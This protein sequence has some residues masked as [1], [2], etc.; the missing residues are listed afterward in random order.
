MSCYVY[1]G[2]KP[3]KGISGKFGFYDGSEFVYSQGNWDILN[4]ISLL[5]RY[6]ISLMKLDGLIGEM[7]NKFER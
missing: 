6:G 3:K 1:T 5:W 4:T 7:L 2:L